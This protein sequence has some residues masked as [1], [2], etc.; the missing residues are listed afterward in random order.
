[1]KIDNWNWNSQKDTKNCDPKLDRKCAPKMSDT[2]ALCKYGQG[3]KAKAAACK[4]LR[5]S[6][7]EVPTAAPAGKSLGGAYAM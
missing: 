1:M 4:E 5:E 7:K 2:E 6:G 3:G